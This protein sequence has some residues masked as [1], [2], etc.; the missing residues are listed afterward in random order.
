MWLIPTRWTRPMSFLAEY[1]CLRQVSALHGTCRLPPKSPNIS[2]ELKEANS[3]VHRE[4][5]QRSAAAVLKP[6]IVYGKRMLHTVQS[7]KSYGAHPNW[8]HFLAAG[9]REWW[10]ADI[11]TSTEI[12]SVILS[13][14][15]SKGTKTLD[16]NEGTLSYQLQTAPKKTTKCRPTD[17]CSML[18]NPSSCINVE[19]CG[20][21]R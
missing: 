16:G 19:T 18:P 14:I 6:M 20:E 2:E 15:T 5:R 9:P 17:L 12:H 8:Q 10:C 4:G 7:F 3:W 21:V 1:S 11:Y 13:D